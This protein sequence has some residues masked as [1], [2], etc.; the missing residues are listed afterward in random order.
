MLPLTSPS[1]EGNFCTILN[2]NSR[3]LLLIKNYKN[4][5]C[6]CLNHTASSVVADLTSCIVLN[7]VVKTRF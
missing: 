6:L 3:N 7:L 2:Y 1:A 4:N 5:L